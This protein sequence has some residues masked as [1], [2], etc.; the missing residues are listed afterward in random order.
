LGGR[1]RFQLSDSDSGRAARPI[2]KHLNLK[3]PTRMIH[4]LQVIMML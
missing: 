1:A 3:H 4:L 2:R